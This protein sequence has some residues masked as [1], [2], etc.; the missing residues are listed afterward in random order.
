MQLP[1]AVLITLL[2]Q[3]CCQSSHAHLNTWQMHWLPQPAEF[4]ILLISWLPASFFCD[5]LVDGKMKLPAV[6]STGNLSGT[7]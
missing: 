1:S 4:E 5:P 2:G 6:I 3:G 7:K